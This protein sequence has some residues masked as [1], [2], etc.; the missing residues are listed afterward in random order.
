MAA[1]AGA[2]P[3]ASIRKSETPH[4]RTPDPRPP[5][6]GRRG[7]LQSG[8]CPP[9]GPRRGRPRRGA[10]D[11]AHL[12]GA[13]AA[14]RRPKDADGREGAGRH[15]AIDPPHRRLDRFNPRDDLA[16]DPP[17]PEPLRRVLHGFEEGLLAESGRLAGA[18]LLEVLRV[19][20]LI[21]EGEVVGARLD[22]RVVLTELPPRYGH[23]L[24]ADEA[25]HLPAQRADERLALPEAV[26]RLEAV[27]LLEMVAGIEVSEDRARFLPGSPR[28][29]DHLFDLLAR[30]LR[31]TDVSPGR[32]ELAGAGGRGRPVEAGVGDVDA[33]A[34]A[35]EDPDAGHGNPGRSR[36]RIPGRLLRNPHRVATP[37][38]IIRNVVAGGPLASRNGEAA[39]K[40]SSTGTLIQID[41]RPA[42][43]M[44][45]SPDPSPA[46]VRRIGRPSASSAHDSSIRMPR[47][48]SS[49]L[50]SMG[51][52][53][54]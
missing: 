23:G 6:A 49:I 19:L 40:A 16:G 47:Q 41:L 37:R 18:E 54:P 28:H 32:A 35:L 29:L 46:R 53:T 51:D 5:R 45:S 7:I 2:A 24:N 12:L 27:H 3:P 1:R 25:A 39:A 44:T 50:S 26:D 15:D 4:S 31:H 52:S 10:R 42:G 34:V 14:D 48:K 30:L 38:R 8:G 21:A 33:E 17:S 9:E 11:L 20:E 36:A 43:R 13:L 22:E